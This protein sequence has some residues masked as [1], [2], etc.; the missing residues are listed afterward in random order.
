M[1]SFSHEDN[2]ALLR[3]DSSGADIAGLV[4]VTQSHTSAG[5]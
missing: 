4:P 1:F 5:K 2:F 3:A